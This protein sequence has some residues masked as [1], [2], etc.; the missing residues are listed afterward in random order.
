MSGGE[1][2]EHALG[3]R[4]G[5]ADVVGNHLVREVQVQEDLGHALRA[6]TSEVVEY[7]LAGPLE[8]PV[9]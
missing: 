3:V 2:V 4:E 6:Q 7:L 1:R 9:P 5:H 8:L